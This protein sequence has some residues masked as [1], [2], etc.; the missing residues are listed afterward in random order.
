MT[1][2]KAICILFQE[3]TPFIIIEFFPCKSVRDLGLNNLPGE[4]TAVL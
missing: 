1:S 4:D 3:L 2:P